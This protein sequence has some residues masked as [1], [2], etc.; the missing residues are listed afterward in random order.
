MTGVALPLA[1][2]SIARTREIRRADW[3]PSR[4]TAAVKSGSVQSGAAATPLSER[5]DRH[6]ERKQQDQRASAVFSK[7]LLSIIDFVGDLGSRRSVTHDADRV[8]Q[9]GHVVDAYRNE[10]EAEERCTGGLAPKKS[11]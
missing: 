10:I 2:R 1:P 9:K 11:E 7:E 6:D 8:E 4:R 3:I 5:D